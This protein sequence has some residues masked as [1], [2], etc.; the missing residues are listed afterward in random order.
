LRYISQGVLGA[1]H[2]PLVSCNR[3]ISLD[4]NVLRH[5]ARS[6]NFA[7][8]HSG[9]LLPLYK[10]VSFVKFHSFLHP[11][12]HRQGTHLAK[13]FRASRRSRSI[14]M[15]PSGNRGFTLPEKHD[16]T[17]SIYSTAMTKDFGWTESRRL[18]FSRRSSVQDSLITLWE[19]LGDDGLNCWRK[20]EMWTLPL[21][22][23][24]VSYILS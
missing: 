4:T 14:P 3:L 6:N 23:L 21:E 9:I 17:C 22:L 15:V 2:N 12:S 19:G 10:P 24:Q 18:D 8:P 11:L 20:E 7:T 13:R 16:S 1:S 5:A